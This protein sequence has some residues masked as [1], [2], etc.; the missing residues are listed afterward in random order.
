[1]QTNLENKVK[2]NP[3]LIVY[4]PNT[5]YSPTVKSEYPLAVQMAIDLGKD[6][7]K[8]FGNINYTDLIIENEGGFYTVTIKDK[9][10]D[11]LFVHKDGYFWDF[12]FFAKLLDEP[13]GEETNGWHNKARDYFGRIFSKIFDRE[14]ISEDYKTEIDSVFTRVYGVFDKKIQVFGIAKRCRK[15]TEIAEI[16]LDKNDFQ[17]KGQAYWWVIMAD[18]YPVFEKTTKSQISRQEIC[19]AYSGPARWRIVE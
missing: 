9:S 7:M 5:F 8:N 16:D 4:K 18:I 19:P 12:N 1:M 13:L 10:Y 15:Y 2:K 3:P 11:G 17:L 14:L 6:W